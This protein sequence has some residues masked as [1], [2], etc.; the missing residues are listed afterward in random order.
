MTKLRHLISMESL[1]QGSIS[2]L[3]ERANHFLEYFVN[4]NAATDSLRGK[5]VANLF[6]EPSTRTRNSFEIAAHR[7][8]AMSL[9]PEMQSSAVTKGESMRDT[10]Q[11]FEAM[12]ASI[13]VV[14]HQE[15]GIMDWMAEHVQDSTAIINAGDGTNQHPTQALIDLLT[16][17]QHKPDFKSLT[18]TIIGDILHSRVAHSL[19]NGLQTM[20]VGAIRLVGP[21]NLMPDDIKGNNISVTDS[22]DEGLKNSDVIVCLRVQK[23]R[24]A[25]ENIPDEKTFHQQYGLTEARLKLAKPD[26]I[27]MHPGPMN[28]NVEIASNVA[29]GPQSVILEQVR[30]GVAI[31]MAVMDMLS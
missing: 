2:G 29:D 18:V 14:R 23:E 16:I 27:V 30:N 7:L 4:K 24:I 17:Q 21:K 6:F 5:I 31:R 10:L 28:R 22:M 12:G 8:G 3:L 9:N 26:A 13:L 11:T 25:K 19:I 15:S 20:Q 1:D